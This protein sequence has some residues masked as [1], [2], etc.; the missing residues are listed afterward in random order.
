MRRRGR[1]PPAPGLGETC[2]PGQP[3]PAGPLG[4]HYC[5]SPPPFRGS[6]QNHSWRP[7]CPSRG[8]PCPL[9]P[10]PPG[11]SLSPQL[12]PGAP[13]CPSPSTAAKMLS[14]LPHW[15][16]HPVSSQALGRGS[17]EITPCPLLQGLR[18]RAEALPSTPT[19]RVTP[20][21]SCPLSRGIQAP[22]LMSREV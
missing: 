9:C 2:P 3:S 14:A 13:S 19:P 7:E 18:N 6:K 16:G 5:P 22:S 20:A 1:R 10:L 8:A 11:P 17:P 12:D 21:R 15:G 4:G